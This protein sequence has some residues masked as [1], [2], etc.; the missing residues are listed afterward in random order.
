[1]MKSMTAFGRATLE[2]SFGK[3]IVEIHSVNRKHLE[4]TTHLPRELLRYDSE[5]KKWISKEIARGQVG[6]RVQATFENESPLNIT[7]NL[8]LAR[9]LK[10]GWE[11]LAKDFDVEIDG[12]FALKM[13]AREPELFLYDEILG[14][15]VTGLKD[16]VEAALKS[17][18]VMKTKEGALLQADVEERLQ[19]LKNSLEKIKEKAPFVADKLRQRLQ[20]K[21]E[22]VLK[23]S[24]DNEER[25]LREVALFAEKVDI[26]EEIVRFTSH[27]EQFQELVSGGKEGLGKTLDFLIQELLREANTMGSKANEAAITTQVIDIKSELEKIREQIQNVE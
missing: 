21:L 26:S 24:L 18:L 6:V 10:K 9:Q 22:E 1:M 5:I 25:L 8:P 11:A 16:V 7:P 13:I 19:K 2:N 4:I 23:G 20:L 14:E 12:K 17:L 15:D 27:L 3:F